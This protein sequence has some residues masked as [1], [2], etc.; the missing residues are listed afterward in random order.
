MTGLACIW[1]C[2]VNQELISFVVQLFIWVILIVHFPPFSGKNNETPHSVPRGGKKQFLKVKYG[3]IDWTLFK[4]DIPWVSLQK[5]LGEN[6]KFTRFYAFSKSWRLTRLLPKCM[7]NWKILLKIRKSGVKSGSNHF[8]VPQATGLLICYYWGQRCK[9]T[10]KNHVFHQVLS[11]LWK[12]ILEYV[13]LVISE[14]AKKYKIIYHN[15]DF[16]IKK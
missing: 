16:L 15:H 10:N 14:K 5:K 13:I 11:I 12:N 9:F 8:F 6:L 2:I 3:I 4:I 7:Y 1:V